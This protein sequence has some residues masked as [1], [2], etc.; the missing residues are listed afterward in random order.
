MIA[1]AVNRGVRAATWTTLVVL[2]AVAVLTTIALVAPGTAQALGAPSGLNPLDE[3]C[4]P[5]QHMVIP[6]G[7]DNGTTSSTNRLTRYTASGDEAEGAGFAVV[8]SVDAPSYRDP[9]DGL[10]FRGFGLS[11]CRDTAATVTTTIGDTAW[12]LLAVWPAK[13]VGMALDWALSGALTTM[14][15][16]LVKA[17]MQAL[18]DNVFLAWAPLVIG[19]TLVGIMFTVVRRRGRGFGDFVW[20]VGVIAALGLLVSPAGIK[21]LGT[22][23]RTVGQLATCATTAPLGGCDKGA[24]VS[25][26]I[27]DTIMGRAW[28][29]AALGDVGDQP[30]PG[31]IT[32]DEALKDGVPDIRDGYTV[33]IPTDAIPAGADGVVSYADTFRWTQAYTAAEATR[34]A[35]DPAQRCSF[36]DHM[37]TI[38]DVTGKTH[39]DV[40]PDELCSYKAVVRAA[41]LSDLASDH[42]GAYASATGRGGAAIGAAMAALFGL[43]PMLIALA[44]IAVVALLAEIRLVMLAVMSPIVGLGALRNPGVGKRWATELAATAVRRIAV[45]AALGLALALVSGVTWAMTK[46]LAGNGALAGVAIAR[47][48][49]KLLPTAIA[50]TTGL[51][52]VATV[53]VM[54]KLEEILMA[55]AG[56]PEGAAGEVVGSKGKRVTAAAVG[57]TAGA[58][59]APGALLPGALA[60]LKRTAGTTS[61]T[62]AARSGFGAGQ[63]VA[64]RKND[65]PTRD[66]GQRPDPTRKPDPGPDKTPR[67]TPPR[68]VPPPLPPTH[69]DQPTPVNGTPGPRA[70]DHQD[71]DRAWDALTR[72][73]PARAYR[74]AERAVAEAEI[75][76][77]RDALTDAQAQFDSYQA[78]TR[79]RAAELTAWLVRERGMAPLAAGEEALTQVARESDDL[80]HLVNGTRLA[81]RRA[82]DAMSAAANMP[83]RYDIAADAWARSG[84][85]IADAVQALGLATETEVKAFTAYVQ[86]VRQ[87]APTPGPTDVHGGGTGDHGWWDAGLRGAAA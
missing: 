46:L 63:G 64:A 2:L 5:D 49:P 38:G 47:V 84:A 51:L 33:V 85:P 30:I 32:L 25:T 61:V 8:T 70:G 44:C 65:A 19:L 42:P 59:G 78:R 14:M 37:P 43:L 67:R 52:M 4:K 3:V 39:G 72:V 18:Y 55:S 58:L 22:A 20:M 12:Q 69:D 82:E 6:E 54:R 15:L 9:G 86:M 27:V 36:R 77:L 26:T 35:S 17:P 31:R 13:L 53:Q 68:P 10:I 23:S 81:V 7:G 60:G 45:G 80:Q 57:A 76:R 24:S 11:M 66:D 73:A 29:A 50:I 74:D 56:L 71:A 79:E 1:R 48:A 40:R 62:R 28:G 16:D 21:A 83:T 75:G 41:I 87:E 34:I